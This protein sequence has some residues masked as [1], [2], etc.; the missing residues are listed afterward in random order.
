[1]STNLHELDGPSCT[2][3][4]AARALGI[5]RAIAYKLART[6]QLPGVFRL[7]GRYIVGTA[8]LRAALG[9]RV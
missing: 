4:Q 6:G 3:E 8:A 7:G 2:V 9:M 1:M 5:S